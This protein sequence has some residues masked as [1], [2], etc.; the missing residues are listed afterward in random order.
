MRL[1]DADKIKFEDIYEADEGFYFNDTI[2]YKGQIDKLP[3]ENKW[4]LRSESLPEITNHGERIKQKVLVQTI[5]GEF[6]VSYLFRDKDGKLYWY[7]T[8]EWSWLAGVNKP[9]AWM[10]LPEPYKGGDTE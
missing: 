8:G 1:I 10:P 3:T 5:R 9:L 2:A 4:I 7:K 6:F